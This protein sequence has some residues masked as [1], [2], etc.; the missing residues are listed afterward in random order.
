MSISS[1]LWEVRLD[2]QIGYIFGSFH[3]KSEQTFLLTQAVYPFLA[4]SDLLCLEVDLD[5]AQESMNLQDMQT[6]YDLLPEKK[7]W[8]WRSRVK[9]YY[10]EDLGV[11]LHKP[12]IIFYQA[13]MQKYF[14]QTV[15]FMV[16]EQLWNFAKEHQIRRQGLESV[17]SQNELLRLMHGPEIKKMITPA[18]EQIERFRSHLQHF[19]NVYLKQDIRQLYLMG[20][21]QS[22]GLRKILIYKRNQ[23]M[24]Q[25]IIDLFKEGPCP[26]IA[27]GAG[28]L[29]GEYGLLRLLKAHGARVTPIKLMI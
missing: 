14:D 16:D 29:S 2:H 11:Y 6:L 13:L 7:L 23:H 22:G 3:I 24:A 28:H 18:I 15:P 17:Q 19:L 9:K 27:V 20:K 8:R 26:F 1:L 4:S 5:E 25:R 21:K 12:A 10:G